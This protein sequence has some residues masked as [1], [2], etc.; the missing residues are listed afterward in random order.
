MY[1]YCVLL[2]CT[3][4]HI[5]L[6]FPQDDDCTSVPSS[7]EH[8]PSLNNN[9]NQQNNQEGEEGHE[10]DSPPPPPLPSEEDTEEAVMDTKK[11][12]NASS[13]YVSVPHPPCLLLTPSSPLPPFYHFCMFV[14]QL[15]CT[16]H[17]YMYLFYVPLYSHFLVDS[18]PLL[19]TLVTS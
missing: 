18:L 9:T 5:S 4:V 17:V 12:S 10:P 19:L 16:V 3:C 1:F 2:V 14:S 13:G 6:V 7:L 8:Q 15:T 11:Q